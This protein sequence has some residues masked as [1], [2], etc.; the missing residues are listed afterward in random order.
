MH[1]VYFRFHII[2]MHFG[3]SVMKTFELPHGCIKAKRMTVRHK[4]AHLELDME[5][6]I[7]VESF[8][9]EQTNELCTRI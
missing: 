6:V 4:I 3:E 5:F 9:L 2:K 1:K 8:T 7:W